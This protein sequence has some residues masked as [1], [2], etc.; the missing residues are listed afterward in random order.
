[1]KKIGFALGCLLLIFSSTTL[2]VDGYKDI[3]FGSSFKQLQNANL[4]SWKRFTGS[5]VKGFE[6]FYCENFQFGSERTMAMAFFINGQFK[7][8]G[9]V[10]DSDVAAV[11][12][13]LHKKY[14]DPS[15]MYDDKKMEEL[16]AYGGSV[17]VSFDK[18]TVVVNL[19]RDPSTKKDTTQLIYTSA[20]YSRLLDELKSKNLENDL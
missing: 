15:S 6:S 13:G 17:S 3:K 9:I 19:N 11:L 7:R 20:D 16:K 5:E 4:C 12:N 18:N 2:A 8:F 14:G 10:F 1:M